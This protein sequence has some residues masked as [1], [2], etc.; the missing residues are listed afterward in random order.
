MGFP[1]QEQWS[2]LSS[3]SLDLPDPVIKPMYPALTGGFFTSE[4]PGKPLSLLQMG[5]NQS[6]EQRQLAY[7]TKNQ[8]K[9]R[10]V[11]GASERRS[12][13]LNLRDGILGKA[14]AGPL[15]LLVIQPR[16]RSEI[17]LVES[18]PCNARDL[19][20]IPG[21]GTRIPQAL[22][23]VSLCFATTEPKCCNKKIPHYTLKIVHATTKTQ[24][25]QINNK[26][27]TVFQNRIGFNPG[28]QPFSSPSIVG[29]KHPHSLTFYPISPA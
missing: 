6:L 13:C 27:N 8:V 29:P 2:V 24:C 20:S 9:G 18:L 23:Q 1:R 17:S 3:S 25:S 5:E 14:G 7:S 22:E 10:G 21:Q 12:K 11:V 19:G 26:I 28:L 4:P 15:T 16:I